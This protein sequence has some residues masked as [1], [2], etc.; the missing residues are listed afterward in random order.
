MS[1]GSFYKKKMI[2]QGEHEANQVLKH[3]KALA[4]VEAA[5][6]KQAQNNIGT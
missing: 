6:R 3:V 1:V 5:T 4:T 2:T